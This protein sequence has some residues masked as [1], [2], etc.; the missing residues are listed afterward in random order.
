MNATNKCLIMALFVGTLLTGGAVW[1]FPPGTH[2]GIYLGIWLIACGAAFK[3]AT[4]HAAK[5]KALESE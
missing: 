4:D 5:R 1:L 3:A 2:P